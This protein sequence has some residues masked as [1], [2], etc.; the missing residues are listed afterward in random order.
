M[1]NKEKYLLSTLALTVLGFLTSRWFMDI[2]LWLVD[3]QHVDIVVTKM[4]RIFTSD[5]VFA[6]ILGMLPLLFL[7][8]DTLCGL[9]SLS[10]RLIT[11]GFILG[12]GIIT[13]LFRIVQLNTGFRQI[14]KYNL[15][16][17]TVHALDAGSLQFK[18]FLVFGFLLGAVVSIL[19]FR[20]KNK[21]SEDDIG[22]L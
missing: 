8:V 5:L 22:I 11:I 3:H 7:V 14:S 17:D 19:V 21:R 20:E 13:W 12:F 1:K 4:L 15:G 16:R 2:S 10:Q 9:K 6:V 18:I